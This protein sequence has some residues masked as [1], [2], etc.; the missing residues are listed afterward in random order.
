MALLLEW[1]LGNSMAALTVF[2][3]VGLMVALLA[4]EMDGLMAKG[5]A[6]L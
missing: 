6:V 1:L 5:K 3:K 2:V 4:H